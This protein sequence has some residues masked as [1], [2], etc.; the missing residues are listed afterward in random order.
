MNLPAECSRYWCEW[1]IDHRGRQVHLFHVG[2]NRYEEE[3]RKAFRTKQR[4]D[5]ALNEICV[6]VDV[7]AAP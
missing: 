7:P 4:I 2:S 5:L 3:K 1:D 6:A